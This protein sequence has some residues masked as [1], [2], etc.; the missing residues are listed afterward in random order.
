MPNFKVQMPNL[1][2]KGSTQLNFVKKNSDGFTL[3]EV[4]IYATIFV[5]IGVVI[6]SY[7][8]QIV[9]VTETSRRA[10]ESNDNASRAMNVITQEIR[11]ATAVYTPTSK[12]GT[13]SG[14]LSLETTRDLPDEENTTY[15]D[16]YLDD[17]GIYLKRED[18]VEELLTSEKVKVTNFT[19]THL[20][21][22]TDTSVQVNLTV[23][24]ID[25]ASG[26][27]TPVTLTQ[28]ASLRSF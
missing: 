19:F 22:G 23:E 27:K 11:H 5:I 10:R 26:P 8:I 18:Q 24:Y 20:T 28:T 25:A 3:I 7:F 12:F 17:E 13:N 1:I 6:S 4:L 16:F 14:Q 2:K 9:S 15:V 21:G